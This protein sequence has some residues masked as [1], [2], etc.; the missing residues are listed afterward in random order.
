MRRSRARRVCLCVGGAGFAALIAALFA[1]SIIDHWHLA[2]NYRISVWFDKE[3]EAK[4]ENSCLVPG[5]GGFVGLSWNNAAFEIW[6][7]KI[8]GR[9]DKHLAAEVLR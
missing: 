9:I 3:A 2:W 7:L 5:G 4:P 1:E 6:D 8:R